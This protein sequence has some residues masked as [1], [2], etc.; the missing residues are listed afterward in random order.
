MIRTDINISIRKRHITIYTANNML[1]FTQAGENIE[2]YTTIPFTR[3][4]MKYFDTSGLV[5][6]KRY[7]R[8]VDSGTITLLKEPDYDNGK[9]IVLLINIIEKN[10]IKKAN[11]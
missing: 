4:M 1:F 3:L 8:S 7:I 11:S 6:V 5:S 2:L 10:N 9:F